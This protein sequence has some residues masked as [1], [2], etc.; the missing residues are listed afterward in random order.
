[1]DKINLKDVLEFI[2]ENGNL[3]EIDQ[4]KAEATAKGKALR[5]ETKAMAKDVKAAREAA[6]EALK[7][8]IKIGTIVRFVYGSGKN[9]TT[10][11]SAVVKVTDKT[12]H[13]QIEGKEKTTWRYY[14]QIVGIVAQPETK[15]E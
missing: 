9:Q 11:E 15:A 1:M 10:M 12:F 4:I 3:A 7:P 2:A 13:V 5:E 14:A 6:G 8:E